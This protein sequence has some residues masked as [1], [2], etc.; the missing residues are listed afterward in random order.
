MAH[1]LVSTGEKENKQSSTGSSVLRIRHGGKAASS[2][3]SSPL[4]GGGCAACTHGRVLTRTREM[5]EYAVL[6][7]ILHLAALLPGCEGSFD[8]NH[9]YGIPNSQWL[10]RD[11]GCKTLPGSLDVGSGSASQAPS[12]QERL[13]WQEGTPYPC[14]KEAKIILWANAVASGLGEALDRQWGFL[15]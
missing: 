14:D 6:P 7:V 9:A 1:D 4:S 10:G 3:A 12:G 11:L 13:G 15:P 2:P 8:F 5:V